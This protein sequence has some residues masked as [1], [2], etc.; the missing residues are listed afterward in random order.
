D[1][2]GRADRRITTQQRR[3][4]IADTDAAMRHGLAEQ[5]WCAGPV[6]TDHATTRPLGEL[7]IGARRNRE[8]TEEWIVRHE[9]RG[10]IE[11]AERGFAARGSDRNRCLVDEFPVLEDI[12]LPAASVNH[13]LVP[14]R[15]QLHSRPPNPAE[16][17]VWPKLQSDLNPQLTMS[18]AAARDRE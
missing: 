12:D 11:V 4:R 16:R 7:R 9:T 8:S 17:A 18:V 10:H 5:L 2:N 13:D 3:R 15:R 14:R 6:D 1:R